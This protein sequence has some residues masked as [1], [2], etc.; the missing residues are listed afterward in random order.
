MESVYDIISPVAYATFSFYAAEENTVAYTAALLEP[1]RKKVLT[2]ANQEETVKDLLGENMYDFFRNSNDV[3]REKS[4]DIQVVDYLAGEIF[5]LALLV[6][7]G[8][9]E[10]SEIATAN[11]WVDYVVVPW[12]IAE[13][14][15]RDNELMNVFKIVDPRVLPIVVTINGQEFTHNVTMEFAFGLALFMEDSSEKYKMSMFGREFVFLPGMKRVNINQGE[16]Y[17]MI[18]ADK[19]YYFNTEDFIQGFMTGA[20][21]SGVDHKQYVTGLNKIEDDGSMT[22]IKL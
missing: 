13:G 10:D 2:S 19:K 16:K 5:E 8:H 14:I 11:R 9:E 4:I 21:W 7:N 15:T 6:V 12:D 18:V 3:D 20:M 22:P 17:Q 1:I